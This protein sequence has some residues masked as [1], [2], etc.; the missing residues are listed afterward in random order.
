MEGRVRLDNVDAVR[1]DREWLNSVELDVMETLLYRIWDM[2]DAMTR[3]GGIYGQVVLSSD[4][5]ARKRAAQMQPQAQIG[6]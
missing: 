2:V 6:G 4:E 1:I 5:A 3:T